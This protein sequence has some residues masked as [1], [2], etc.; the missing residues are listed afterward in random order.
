LVL[1]Y[2][3]TK[4]AEYTYEPLGAA[5]NIGLAAPATDMQFTGRE[6]D[7]NGLYYYRARYYAPQWG[8]FVGEDPIGFA[9]GPNLYAY[10]DQ[11]P[12][13]K[14]DPSGRGPIGFRLAL[15]CAAIDASSVLLVGEIRGQKTRSRGR[16]FKRRSRLT[17]EAFSTW[18]IA[19]Q[20]A[21]LTW[22]AAEVKAKVSHVIPLAASERQVIR[23]A[24]GQPVKRWERRPGMQAE[25]LDC[26]TYAT[27]ARKL[28]AIPLDA[29]EDELHA[30]SDPAPPPP[31]SV[32]SPWVAAW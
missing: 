30:R 26:L 13:G 2:D 5:T 21:E 28:L 31:T 18:W 6:N 7:G 27:A 15:V 24:R 20:T 8:R 14:T 25:S 32:A 9:G 23:Y 12:V 1:K 19:Y 17:G 16:I 11:D 3:G 22:D 29:R 10:A 4:G